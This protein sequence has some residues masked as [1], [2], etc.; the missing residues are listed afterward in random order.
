MDGV[1]ILNEEYCI[2]KAPQIDIEGKDIIVIQ[3]K[4]NRIGMYLMGQVFFQKN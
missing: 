1:I 3:T 4:A 2:A